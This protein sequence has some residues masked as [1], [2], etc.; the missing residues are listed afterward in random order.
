[1]MIKTKY[2]KMY[3]NCIKSVKLVSAH[4]VYNNPINNLRRYA[5]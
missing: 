2:K 4:I 5:I 3:N 1:M